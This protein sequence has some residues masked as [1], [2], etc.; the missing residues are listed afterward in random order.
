MPARS[1]AAARPRL[2]TALDV[3]L[4]AAVAT[5]VV[6]ALG[7]RERVLIGP[8]LLSLRDPLRALVVAAIVAAVRFAIGGTQR[9]FP[10]IDSAS[11]APRFDAERARFMEPARWTGAVGGYAAAAVLGSLVW[12]TPHIV[13]IRH[14]PDAGDPVFSAWRL[15]RFAHQLANDPA[16][17]FDGNIFHPAPYTLTYSDATVLEG[18]AAFPF[19]AAGADPLIVSNALF[20][21]S[22]PLCALAFFYAAW[23]LT[24]DPRAACVAGILGGLS[25]FKTEHYSHLELQFF[26]FAPLSIVTLMRLLAAPS[27]RTG[28]VF[29]AVVTAQWLACMYLG[30]M[31]FVFMAPFALLVA[32][33]WRVRPTARLAAATGTAALIVVVGGSIVAV[34]FMRSQRDRGERSIDIVKFYSAEPADYGATHH[35]LATYYSLGSRADNKPERQLF[36]GVLPIALGAIGAVPPLSLGTMALLTGTA[37]AFDGSLGT[38]GLIYD[39]LYKYV[40]PFRGMRVPARFAALVG[41]GLILLGAYGARRAIGL[42]RTP[43]MRSGIFILLAAGALIDVR[44]SVKLEPYFRTPP[45]IYS[46][47]TPDMVLAELPMEA[48]PNF[49]Y[50]YFSTF[51]WARLIN[52]QSGYMP[53]SYTDLERDMEYFPGRNGLARLRERGATHITVNCKLFAKPLRCA[54]LLGVMDAMPELQL[55]STGRWEGRDVRL[56]AIR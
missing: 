40:L 37:V 45:P 17:L 24:D 12:L 33:A 38:N 20:L 54:P 49:A 25:T 23:R 18:L 9:P 55:I 2:I 28:A 32:L 29:G 51:H 42:G 14:V 26:C 21:A 11:A 27:V 39:E 48:V 46:R 56:Y 34:P 3:I 6:L 10:A 7:A 52:G 30:V 19:I 13:N 31:L 47:V 16:R 44:P 36:P 5:A 50:M 22:F 4:I 8:V 41:T 35:N 53:A 1:S 15:A 43:A